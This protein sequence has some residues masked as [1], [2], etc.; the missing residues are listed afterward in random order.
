MS[1]DFTGLD[2]IKP[3]TAQEDFREPLDNEEGTT[4]KGTEK[5][6]TGQNSGTHTH[7][8]DKAKREREQVREDHRIYQEN[9]RKAGDLRSDILK[10][11]KIGEAPLALL[12]KAM[13]CISKMT[14]DQHIYTQ[15]KADI[16]AVYGYGLDQ[17]AP[18][19]ITLEEVKGRHRKLTR[20][21]LLEE[22]IPPETRKRL[23]GAIRAH[24]EVIDSLEKKIT[25]IERGG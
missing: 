5:T 4:P 24:E 18:L 6:A 19:H 25:S 7:Q 20:P 15:S 23:Q 11:L 9:I 10:G 21:E 8:L 17:V 14:G 22:E 12:L 1:L 16:I 3:Q 13:E 2:S